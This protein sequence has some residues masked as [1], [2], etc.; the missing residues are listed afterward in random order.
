VTTPA[1]A[2]AWDLVLTGALA[3]LGLV[4]SLF[5]PGG[6][7]QAAAPMPLALA[8]P[9]Y[10]IAAA[11]F[12][13]GAIERGDR[14]VYSFALSVSAAALGGLVLQVVFDLSRDT[15]LGLLLAVTLA[16][17][18]VAWSR[19]IAM[20]IQTTARPPVRPPAGLLWLAAFLAAIAIAGAAIAIAVH[21]AR[22]QQ[23]KQRFAS[24]WAVPAATSEGA[25][26][27]IVGVWNHGGPAAYRLDV[28]S[29]GRAIQSLRLRLDPDQRWQAR[30]APGTLARRGSLL[31]T[32]YHGSAPY[33]SVELDIEGA[34]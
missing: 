31:L 12:P 3:A 28:S 10:A 24:L 11:L 16:A 7:L 18:A 33:R 15:W 23:G 27:V 1:P 19:R 8:V 34:P 6:W 20:P 21:G 25:R 5:A 30:L 9:G 22:E 4:V 29:G 32:L 2:R 13:P 14:I 26:P 17:S